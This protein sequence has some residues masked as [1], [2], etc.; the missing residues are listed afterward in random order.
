MHDHDCMIRLAHSI[1]GRSPYSTKTCNAKRLLFW[2]KRRNPVRHGESGVCDQ[3][4][5][6]VISVTLKLRLREEKALVLLF[7]Y[8]CLY[9]G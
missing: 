8:L 9:P 2:P 1:L 6:E 5:F 4:A 7:L 3:H